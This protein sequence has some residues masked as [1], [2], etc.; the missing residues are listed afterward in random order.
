LTV[1]AGTSRLFGLMKRSRRK[2]F[3]IGLVV[4][5]LGFLLYRSSGM[6]HLGEFSGQRLWRAIRGANPFYVILS[7]IAIYVCYALRSLRWQVFQ[8]NLGKTHFGSIYRMTLAGFAAVFLLGRAG[9]PIR[10]LLLARSAKHPVADVF[11][12]WVLERLFD[13]ASTAV[14]AAIGLIIFNGRPHAGESAGSLEVAARTTGMFLAFGVMLAMAAL[15]YLRLE[16]SARLERR[17]EG[18]QNAGGWRAGVARIV[19]GFVRG[20]QTIRSW[21]DLGL[22]VLYSMLHWYLVVVIYFWVSKSFG[23]GLAQ[24]SVGDC[25]LVLALTLVGSAVQLPGVGGGSQVACFLAYTA[26]FG[27]EQEPAAAAAILVWLVTFAACSL[28]G[29]PILIHE[30]V[31]LGRL[32]E[33]A[34]EEKAELRDIAE[35]AARHEDRR[36]GEPLE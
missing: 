1:F 36:R 34:A 11:G 9:E 27:V 8:R 17:L 6:L 7:V 21:S 25:M 2:L 5:V 14:I 19:T 22:A 3:V 28:A 10:P 23:G 33:L 16:G 24:L 4:V 31:S 15:V 30:G 35:T 29:I 12:I 18:W 20:I 26:I 13:A 32:R